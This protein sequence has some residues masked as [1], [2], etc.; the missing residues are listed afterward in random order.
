MS[1]SSA[2]FPPTRILSPP[3][4]CMFVSLCLCVVFCK[5]E[6]SFITRLIIFHWGGIM[7]LRERNSS[8]H[9]PLDLSTRG[10]AHN[11]SVSV[12]FPIECIAD[13]RGERFLEWFTSGVCPAGY[14]VGREMKFPQCAAVGAKNWQNCDFFPGKCCS[15]GSAGYRSFCQAW[16]PVKLMDFRIWSRV[17][18]GTDAEKG[19]EKSLSRWRDGIKRLGT[20]PIVEKATWQSTGRWRLFADLVACIHCR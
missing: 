9:A 1:I 5:E 8:L 15:A 18:Q 11:G 20:G 13:R 19:G 16:R 7:F 2:N 4:P 17:P 3:P 14:Q 12:V 10:E 6:G